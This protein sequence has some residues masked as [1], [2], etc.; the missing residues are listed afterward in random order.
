MLLTPQSTPD[1][2]S[3]PLDFQGFCVYSLVTYGILVPGNPTVGVVSYKG[4]SCVFEEGDGL[5]KFMAD[6]GNFFV[7]V[8]EAC[9]KAPELIQPLRLHEDFPKCSL[10]GILNAQ[11]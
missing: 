2:L 10:Y 6:P 9:Y 7:G 1:F 8:R 11:Q 3:M 4:R 5:A